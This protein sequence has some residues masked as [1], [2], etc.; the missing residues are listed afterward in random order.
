MR[1]SATQP[2]SAFQDRHAHACSGDRSRGT[3]GAARDQVVTCSDSRLLVEEERPPKGC[4]SVGWP[5]F[6][7]ELVVHWAPLHSACHNSRPSL[8]SPLQRTRSVRKPHPRFYERL[9]RIAILVVD[10]SSQHI[11][12]LPHALARLLLCGLIHD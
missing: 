9:R 6:M 10:E 3:M 1:R 12:S 2:A 4:L 5:S 7:E 8:T 11:S